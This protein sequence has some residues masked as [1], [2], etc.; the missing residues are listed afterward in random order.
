MTEPPASPAPEDGLYVGSLPTPRRDRRALRLIVPTILWGLCAI[1]ALIAANL[2]PAGDGIWDSDTTTLHGAL[3]ADP[4]PGVIH[5]DDNGFTTT[6]L[7]E[8]GKHGARDTLRRGS[9]RPIAVEGFLIHRDGRRVMELLPG[10]DGVKA[11]TQARFTRTPPATALGT[12]TLRGEIVDYKCYM[13]AMK[14]GHGL[15][16][17]ACATLCISA[18]IPPALVTTDAAGRHTY[19]I[20]RTADR[21]P[22]N[23]DVLPLVATP[24]EITGTVVREADVLYLDTSPDHIK[25]L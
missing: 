4:Y 19:Y 21:Q 9:G 7:V 16:H 24:V 23:Q 2:A 11:K 14:P 25:P 17:R 12:A 15:T 1:S 22:I 13:G 8:A 5:Q 10:P 6:F 3:V 20:L 18:G